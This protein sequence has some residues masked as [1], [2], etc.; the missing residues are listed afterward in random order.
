MG[1][2]VDHVG[3]HARLTPHRLAARD[4]AQDTSYTYAELDRAA[5]CFAAGLRAR[6][7]DV[8][9]R[10]ACLSRNRI[11]CLLLHL[12]C[13]RLGAIYVPLNW[14]LARAELAALLED[15]EPRLVLGDTSLADAGLAGDDIALFAEQALTL[16]PHPA[17]AIDH[18]RP[19]LILYTSGTSGRPKGAMLSERNI[20]RTA[21][22]FSLL[23]RVT[24]ESRFLCDAPMFHVIGLL[25]NLRPALMRGASVLISGGFVPAVTLAR[26][27]DASLGV[28][29]Y[30]CVPQMAQALRAEP[31]FDAGKLK[32]LSAIFTGG[33]PHPPANIRAWLADG[34]AIVDGFGMT[35]TGTVMGMP[36]DRQQIAERAGSAGIIAPGIQSRLIDEQG[37]DCAPGVPGELWLKG[38]NIVKAYW[39]RGPDSAAAFSADH[40]FRTGDI[41]RRDE[42]GFY[43][44]V[45]RRKDMFISGGE[46]VYPAEIEAA[47]AE[48]PAILECA[49]V[50]MADESWGEVGHLFMVTRGT[51]SR[52]E[53]LE[54]LGARL[55]RYKIPKH[56]SVIDALPRNGA[57]K[58]LKHQLAARAVR[59]ADV[60]L[61]TS[62]YG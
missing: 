33:A 28:T 11:E 20:E 34:I 27:G 10:L 24:P 26:L 53:L 23:G 55:A 58:V 14:R 17:A 31:G 37:A 49:V 38:E 48:H 44:I 18:D 52:E 47:I 21:I 9:D 2:A 62:S 43:W 19:S 45:D 59:Q 7:L 29:H 60:H 41:A 22:N 50:G 54:F 57:G 56:I 6:G 12:A 5:A 1:D 51:L 61:P 13:A 32:G 16:A 30:F 4:L 36:L 3:L 46:N 8:G 15:C 40:W 35:E 39:R 25:T 42:D